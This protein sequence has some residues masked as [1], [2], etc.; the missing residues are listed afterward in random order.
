MIV[1]DKAIEP[2]ASGV[3][4]LGGVSLVSCCVVGLT[5]SETVSS[6]RVVAVDIGVALVIL[7]IID[8]ARDDADKASDVAD[9]DP[10]GEK[11]DSSD[12]TSDMDDESGGET[13]VVSEWEGR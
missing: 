4:L 2:E 12:V 1:A 8:G 9:E 13:K 10:T 5:D 7:A 11:R 3:P 6:I